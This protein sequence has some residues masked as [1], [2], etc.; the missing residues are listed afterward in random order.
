M[1]NSENS[2]EPVAAYA[3]GGEQMQLG[4]ALHAPVWYVPDVRLSGT[5]DEMF[6][7]WQ[8][9]NELRQSVT[10]LRDASQAKGALDAFL[11]LRND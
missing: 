6:L 3:L 11:E 7:E 2:G 4:R 1:L 5:D 9:R 10:K 8:F